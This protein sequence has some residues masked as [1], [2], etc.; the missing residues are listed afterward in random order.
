MP[1]ALIS[2]PF[3]NRGVLDAL[4]ALGTT[5]DAVARNLDAMGFKGCQSSEHNCP[6]A[7]Y[8]LSAITGARRA[9]VSSGYADVWDT[10]DGDPVSAEWTAA[11]DEFV[12]LFDNGRL[13]QLE[14][15]DASS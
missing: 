2:Y 7:N 5:A 1:N 3:T 14:A 12:E 10:D 9:G 6:V 15:P 4:K 8:L 13:P 11:V